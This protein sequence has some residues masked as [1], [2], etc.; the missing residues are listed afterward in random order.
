LNI[1]SVVFG[2]SVQNINVYRFWLRTCLEI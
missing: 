1:D 2:K